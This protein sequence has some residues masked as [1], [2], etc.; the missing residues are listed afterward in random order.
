[1]KKEKFHIEYLFDRVTKRSL[2][3]HITSAFGLS[4]WFAD[5]VNINGGSYI[6]TWNKSE[7]T[8]RV[9]FEKPEERIRFKWDS[10]DEGTYF[11]FSIHSVEL[12]GSITLEITDFAE[13][14]DK[15][16]MI[17]LWDSEVEQLK[18][19]LGAY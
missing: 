9:V 13:P 5:K 1:M 8:A 16:N 19:T 2:W 14:S 11:E 10:D 12:T 17:S 4:L 15:A 18:R 7:E 3:N 6:F